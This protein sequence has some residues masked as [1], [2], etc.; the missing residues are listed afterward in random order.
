MRA[1][2]DHLRHQQSSGYQPFFTVKHDIGVPDRN[3]TSDYSFQGAIA[4]THQKILITESMIEGMI[5]RAEFHFND[6]I[7]IDVPS[8][9]SS[10][11]IYLRMK[12]IHSE[13]TSFYPISG[14]PRNLIAEDKIN[15]TSLAVIMK[16]RSLNP[17]S[18]TRLDKRAELIKERRYGGLAVASDPKVALSGHDDGAPETPTKETPY[19]AGEDGEETTLAR[20][21]SAKTTNTTTL[22][23]SSTGKMTNSRASSQTLASQLSSGSSSS[24]ST[25]ARHRVSIADLRAQAQFAAEN[26]HGS[27]IAIKDEDVLARTI[28][29]TLSLGRNGVSS[30]EP[31]FGSDDSD[32]PPSDGEETE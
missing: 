27:P 19:N 23:T 5:N 30:G 28:S 4:L 18:E 22:T 9:L 16:F 13:E 8:Q 21:D 15:G 6:P 12:G 24:V 7:S 14:F 3:Q 1:L 31:D 17:K 29:A 32:G 20:A 25:A 11:T 10:T 2:G 26:G